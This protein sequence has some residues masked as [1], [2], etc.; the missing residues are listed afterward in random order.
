M[1][2]VFLR[3]KLRLLANGLRGQ[4]WRL[5]A[6]IIAALYATVLAV[7]GF[8]V[9]A[10]ARAR[11]TDGDVVAV[12]VGTG[13]AVG[14]AV[15]PLLGFGSDE[16]LDPSRLALLPLSRRQL[17]TGL[18]VAS[19]AGLGGAGT[20]VALCGG[21]VGF[22]HA[23][24]AAPLVVLAAA[25]QLLVC[26][27]LSRA[28]VT[29]LS[30]ALRS[31]KGRD[32][33]VILVALVA[34]VPQAVRFTALSG[35][36]HGLGHLSR[37][38]HLANVLGWLPTGL[39]M[40]ALVAAGRGR[41]GVAA[42]EL[43][44]VGGLV[45]LLM[46]WWASSLDHILTTAEASATPSVSPVSP[47][48]SGS[49]A[50]ARR[51]SVRTESSEPLFGLALAWLPR[52]RAGVVAAREIRSSWREPRRRV[53]LVSE[54]LLPFFV[55]AGVLARGVSH[56]PAIVY[57]ALLVVLLG[58]VRI[59]N[60][61]GF[62]GKAWWVHEASGPDMAADL[63][64]K[65]LALALTVAPV[66]LIP[67]VGLA[68]LSGGWFELVTVVPLAAGLIGIELAVGNVLSVRAPYPVPTSRT[69]L[70][71][72]QTGQGCLNGVMGLVGMLVQLLL[73]APLAAAIVL[74]HG[75]APRFAVALLAL[76]AGW[77]VWR[78]GLRAGV[79]AA[80]GRGPELL[81]AVSA[82]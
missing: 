24:A 8:G 41:V 31:R 47:A 1:A 20:V 42:V 33:R 78:A 29:S 10:S 2:R 44:L 22:V 43:V 7:A 49:R 35:N 51:R 15:F 13:L 61:I 63:R 26:I 73:S 72:T 82:Y 76:P 80:A 50:R 58:G 9:L 57:A 38:R 56:R 69:N 64:G 36:R 25:G 54:V 70:W 32:L 59:Y 39:S 77:G 14:W 60:Q 48:S 17:V 3:L 67:A 74:V 28:V 75:P 12:L 65:N 66:V 27:T 16:T 68:V 62:D 53:Q 6:M 30:A 37:Y 46:W 71:A 40:R 45:A 79:R 21:V 52:T 81:A 18:L 5:V 19:I 23:N 4:G 11:A 55:L 34:F